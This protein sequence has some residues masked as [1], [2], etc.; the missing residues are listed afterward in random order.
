MSKTPSNNTSSNKK[1]NNK[2]PRN[3]MPNNRMQSPTLVVPTSSRPFVAPQA[4]GAVRLA[5]LS[6]ICV[7]LM[8]V[9]PFLYYYHAYPRTTFYQEWTAAFLGLCAMPFLVQGRF[10][11]QPEIPRIVLLPVGLMMLLV[12]QYAMGLIVYFDQTLLYSLYLLWVALLMMVGHRLRKELSLPLVAT[13]MAS[14]LLIGA[15]LNALL[16]VL[17]HYRWHTFLDSVVTVKTSTAVYG[18]IAQP[19]HFANYIALGLISLGLLRMRFSMPAWQTFPLALPLLFVLVLSGSRSGGLYLIWMCALALLWYLM[20]KIPSPTVSAETLTAAVRADKDEIST[21]PL[22]RKLSSKAMPTLGQKPA[23]KVSPALSLLRYTFLLVLGYGLMHFVVQLPVFA[24]ADGMVTMA[25]R[26]FTGINSND[27]RLYLWQE[28]WL[29]FKQFPLLGSGFGQYAWQHFLLTEQL[30]A[31]NIAGLYNN[32]HNLI[33]QIAAEMGVAGLLV[34][35][36]TL[37]LWVYQAVKNGER[38]IYH[39]WGYSILA[40]QGIHSLLEYPLWYAYFLGVAALTLGMLDYS[41]YRLELRRLG[42]LSVAIMILL[43][44]LSLIQMWQGYRKLEVL[45][46]MRPT[47]TA[48]IQNFNQTLRQGMVDLQEST[49]MISVAELY[50]TNMIEVSADHL[51][52]KRT[53]NE[54]VMRSIPIS[55]VVYR[56]ALLLAVSGEQEAAKLQMTRAIWSYPADFN[57]V[58]KQLNELASKDPAHFAALLEFAVQKYQEWQRDVHRR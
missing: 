58:Q 32:A 4:L 53:V 57:N 37:A 6:L 43:G 50:M 45:L 46:A 36:G 5:L 12:I 41:T 21:R 42:R 16:G 24:G 48:D 1:P 38:T 47:S 56:Q 34:L 52:E 20:G 30:R 44:L 14:C 17:Q 23:S 33:L 18:N 39:W 27:I 40:V 55:P 28:G 7:G 8:W 15:E 22:K 19:N 13:V 54:R 26:L 49:M 10:W 2:S 25:Q 35:L 9:L 29:I 31:P 11:V 3:R 51:A